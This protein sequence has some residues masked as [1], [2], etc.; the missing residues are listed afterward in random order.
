M[1]KD[2]PEPGNGTERTKVAAVRQLVCWYLVHVGGEIQM[3]AF[4]MDITN[5]NQVAHRQFT[6][7]A[8]QILL[9]IL[10]RQLRGIKSNSIEIELVR[11]ES[12]KSRNNERPRR[13]S[14]LQREGN[15]RSIAYKTVRSEPQGQ[16]SREIVVGI[17]LCASR[18]L[19]NAITA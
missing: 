16:R 10:K 18:H 3:G 11:R 12:G 5:V 8:Q 13:R 14:R 15:I 7:N 2:A 6:L 9:V 17:K 1:G 19:E 4:G